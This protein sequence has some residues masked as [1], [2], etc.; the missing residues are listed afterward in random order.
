M[1]EES[2]ARIEKGGRLTAEQAKEIEEGNF[3]TVSEI[4]DKL[5]YSYQW[6]LWNLQCGRI[7]GVKPLGRRWRIPKSEFDNLLQHGLPPWPKEAPKAPS[8]M[9]VVVDEKVVREKI[10]EQEVKKK[11]GVDFFGLDFSGL[12]GGKKK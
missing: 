6:V 2:D 4:A 7:K 9:E 11:A 3:L 1:V 8:V 5:Q 12:F 10:E